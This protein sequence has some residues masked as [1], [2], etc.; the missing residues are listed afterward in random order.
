MRSVIAESVLLKHHLLMLNRSRRRAPNLQ[1]ADRLI[2]GL[3]SL[4][5]KSTR[6]FRT[7]IVVKPSTVLSF[8]QALIRRKYRLLFSLKQRAKPGPKGGPDADLIRAIVEM[9]RRNPS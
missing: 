9:K 2:A 4:F 8:H 7:A 3:C 6:L 5:M 1:F